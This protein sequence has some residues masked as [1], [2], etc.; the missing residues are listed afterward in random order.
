MDKLNGILIDLV[1]FLAMYYEEAK[2]QLNLLAALHA[3]NSNIIEENQK[4]KDMIANVKEK[5]HKVKMGSCKKIQRITKYKTPIINQ[6]T[7]AALTGG[8]GLLEEDKIDNRAAI[9]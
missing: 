9:K 2:R 6:N 5:Q 8:N 1:N 3:H 7:Y 4:E